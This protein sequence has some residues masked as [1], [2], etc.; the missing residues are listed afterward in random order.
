MKKIIILIPVYNDWQSLE[1]LIEDINFNFKMKVE[2]LSLKN[3]LLVKFCQFLF[4]L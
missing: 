1:R 4:D 2:K 3:L